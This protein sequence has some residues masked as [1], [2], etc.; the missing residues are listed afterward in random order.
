MPKRGERDCLSA[1]LFTVNGLIE[2]SDVPLQ[3]YRILV[4]ATVGG[5]CESKKV[6]IAKNT[7][8]VLRVE[9]E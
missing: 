2:F 8:H 3:I 7:G 4:R 9:V 5:G 1:I 6:R